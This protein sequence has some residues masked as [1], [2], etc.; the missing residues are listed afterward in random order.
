MNSSFSNKSPYEKI[1]YHIRLIKEIKNGDG[2]NL[3]FF[4]GKA[5][6]MLS[7]FL[8]FNLITNDYFHDAHER[9]GNLQNERTPETYLEESV[10]LNRT[11]DRFKLNPMTF[12]WIRLKK[13]V[14]NSTSKEISPFNG[15]NTGILKYLLKSTH[16]GIFSWI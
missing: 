13:Y 7:V 11:Y 16:S 15:L 6:G 4:Q 5:T 1:E 14:I 9:L 12:R 2:E 10:K 3:A 8:R